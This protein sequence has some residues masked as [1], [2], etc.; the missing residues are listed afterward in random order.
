MGAYLLD[1]LAERGWEGETV[2]LH[3]A[4]GKTERRAE[5]L[6]AVERADVI[7]LAFPLY[8]DSLPANVVRALEII[9]EHR[10]AGSQRAGQRLVAIVNSGF[11]EAHHNDTAVAICK[12]FARQAG[13]EWAGG[14]LLGGGGAI[15][16]RSLEEVGGAARFAMAAL[17][18]ASEA[19]ADG[20]PLPE[21][22]VATMAKPMIPARAYR[23]MGW[24]GWR[25]QAR[26]NG[27]LGKLHARPYG[28]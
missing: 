1:Q 21:E 12:Q 19:L 27:V 2:L 23:W 10:A 22:A 16:G 25:I 15:G 13:F 26:Q 20:G 4:L 7:A 24:L 18:L 28:A 17:D 6:S 14:L 11:P 3:R 9:D 8:V 5:L